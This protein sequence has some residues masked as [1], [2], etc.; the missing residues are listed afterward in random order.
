M[1]VLG[2]TP[3]AAEAAVRITEVAWMG[4]IDNANAE[5]IEL[6]ND[7]DD[8]SLSG[9]TLTSSTGS[10]NITLSGTVARESFFLLTRTNINNVPGVT[11]DQAY[12]G[13]LANT[14]ATLTLTDGSGAVV[15]EVVG[16]ADWENIGGDNTTKKTPQRGVSGWVTATPTPKAPNAEILGEEETEGTLE[17]IAT[18]TPTTTIGG[19]TTQKSVPSTLPKLYVLPGV[20]CIVSV[21]AETVY[22]AS[23]FD[24]KGKA[25][26]HTE[27]SWAFGD[28]SKEIGQEVRHAY[29]VPGTYLVAVRATDDYTS[30]LATLTVEARESNVS[31]SAVT[32]LGIEVANNSDAVLDLSGWH[33]KVGGKKFRLPGDT[34]L[35]PHARVT[36]PYSVTGLN[37]GRG[38]VSLLYPGGKVATVFSAP[39]VPL[40]SERAVGE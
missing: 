10:P 7:G 24:E 29:A 33:L 3:T 18:S 12:T 4:I 13:A 20:N 9:W 21:D 39:A 27:V 11:G 15:D 26:R 28:G 14:G 36:F 35:L 19:L 37:T 31:V 32:N 17:E 22:Q 34:A 40:L 5:W 8:V 23:V 16:G 30:T 38:D 6:Y 2:A 1:L 25:K